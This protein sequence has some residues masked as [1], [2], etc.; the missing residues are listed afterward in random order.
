[1]SKKKAEIHNFLMHYFFVS[2]AALLLTTKSPKDCEDGYFTGYLISLS[3]FS[4]FTF[5]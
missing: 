4:T 3:M 2:L 5:L 1:M